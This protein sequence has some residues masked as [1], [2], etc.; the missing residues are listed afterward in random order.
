MIYATITMLFVVLILTPLRVG[1]SAELNLTKLTACVKARLFSV[2]VFDECFELNGVTLDCSGTIDSKVDLRGFRP[3]GGKYLIKCLTFDELCFGVY[4]RISGKYGIFAALA[5]ECI[6]AAATTLACAASH[7]KVR[8]KTEFG[9]GDERFGA[10]LA[11][12]TTLAEFVI[13]LI[14]EGVNRKNG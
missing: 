11:V 13:A 9:L 5:S 4:S 3:S 12:T 7:C 10:E 1:I 6:T 2:K 14:K 8:S